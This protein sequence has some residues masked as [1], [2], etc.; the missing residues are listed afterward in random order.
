LLGQVI[1]LP[2]FRA[3]AVSPPVGILQE[4]LL[5]GGARVL[6]A[7]A[8]A[9]DPPTPA[10]GTP[11][12]IA[13]EGSRGDRRVKAW[14][15]AGAA[16]IRPA[17]VLDMISMKDAPDPREYMMHGAEPTDARVVEVGG[18]IGSLLCAVVQARSGDETVLEHSH[19]GCCDF[20]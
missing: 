15:A 13:W 18:P 2:P 12:I 11:F 14:A 7:S 6:D 3:S 10:P 8:L 4:V 5:L 16:C 9:K 19:S 20:S 1:L 17:Y